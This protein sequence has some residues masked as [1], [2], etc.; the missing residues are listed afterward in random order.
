M[1][2]VRP[3]DLFASAAETLV[4][5]TNTAGPM[6]AG[7]ARGFAQR[8]PGLEGDYRAACDRGEVH[9]GQVWRWVGL[10]GQVVCLPTKRHWRD[11]ARLGDVDRALGDLARRVGEWQLGSL[12]VP[13][14]GCGEGRLAWWRVAPLLGRRLGGLEI[15][16]EVYPPTGAPTWQATAAFLTNPGVVPIGRTVR[17][18]LDGQVPRGAIYVG[19]AWPR[20]RLPGSPL[21]NPYRLANPDDPTARC[22]VL[23][24]YRD[25]LD[26]A[27]DHDAQ[28]RA[29]L[30]Q[31]R[32][33]DL[34]C[35]CAPR[36]CH[37]D[38]IAAWLLRH[39]APRDPRGV[40]VADQLAA[41]TAT[42]T[43]EN[44]ARLAIVGSKQLPEPDAPRLARLIILDELLR[45][46]PKQL[47]SGGCVGV[48]Q[49]AAATARQLG[50]GGPDQLV[51]H[52]PVPVRHPP[53]GMSAFAR[54]GFQQRDDEIAEACSALL[55]LWSRSTRTW[56]SGWTAEATGRLGK[57]VGQVLL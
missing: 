15:P 7:L 47:H 11:P 45:L 23:E 57:P 9:P 6:G 27:A 44:S 52:L 36:P 37:A 4:C 1:I 22:R 39:P 56:G 14:L 28:V 53:A 12:A 42:I 38:V 5:P 13:A 40:A 51:E 8:Y 26:D 50:L 33:R 32:G 19:R 43:P 31:V 46:R 16:V 30:E 20:R 17:C 35:W 48:D 21:A 10:F 55:R 18:G 24:A 3:G 2:T 54:R 29:A 34:A 41:V 49:L 25:W